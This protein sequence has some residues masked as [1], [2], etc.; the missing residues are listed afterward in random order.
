MIRYNKEKEIYSIDKSMSAT[1][2]YQPLGKLIKCHIITPFKLLPCCTIEF[3]GM[4]NTPSTKTQ[5][6]VKD[7]TT[8]FAIR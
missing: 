2:L 6:V 1:F 7:T 8:S 4:V 3:R 5:N